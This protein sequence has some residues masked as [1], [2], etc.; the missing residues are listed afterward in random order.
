MYAVSVHVMDTI[1][2]FYGRKVAQRTGYRVVL[3]VGTRT[4]FGIADKCLTPWAFENDFLTILNRDN[5]HTVLTYLVILLTF[6]FL[7]YIYF[8][9]LDTSSNPQKN[10]LLRTHSWTLR[11]FSTKCLK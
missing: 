11:L 8:L 3:I 6:K 4:P 10:F 5:N 9:T 7:L 1:V 2:K